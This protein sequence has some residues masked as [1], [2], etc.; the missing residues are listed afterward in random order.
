M[1]H[2]EFPLDLGLYQLSRGV[3]ARFAD[4]LFRS[5]GLESLMLY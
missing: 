3:L 1:K 4:F 5:A 2:G